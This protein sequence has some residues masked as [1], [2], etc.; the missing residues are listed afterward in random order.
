LTIEIGKQLGTYEIVSP[1][2]D[3]GMVKVYRKRA[4]CEARLYREY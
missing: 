2:G 3:G 1:L 4:R